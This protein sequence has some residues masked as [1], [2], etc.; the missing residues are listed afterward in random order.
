MHVNRM[1]ARS[2]GACA[3]LSVAL[4][5]AAGA[6]ARTDS[7]KPDAPVFRV[8]AIVVQA[9]RPVAT[10]GGSSALEVRLDSMRLHAA[11]TLEQVMRA[12]PFVH[13]RTNARGEGY[14]STRGSGF[15]AREVAVLVDGI[16]LSLGFDQRADL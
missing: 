3:L 8:G 6:Q 10:G 16:P 14:F 2:L 5:N 4:V 7:L 11:P 15:D 9:L 13:V 12:L 1:A